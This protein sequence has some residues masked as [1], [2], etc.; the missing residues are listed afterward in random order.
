[1]ASS[2]DTYVKVSEDTALL[3]EDTK[4]PKHASQSPKE[5]RLYKSLEDTGYGFFHVILTVV[6]GWALASDSVEVLCI[7]FAI[8]VAEG[9]LGL[10]DYDKATLDSIIFVGMMIGGLFWGSWSDAVGRRTCLMNSLLLN[11]ASGLLSAFMPNFAGFLF[12]RLLSGIG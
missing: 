10:T 9:E 12:F 3:E 5:R 11:G 7:S 2:G 6:C 8:P 1:M 4:D